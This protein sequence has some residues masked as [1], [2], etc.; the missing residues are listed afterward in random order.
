MLKQNSLSQYFDQI[1]L[2]YIMLLPSLLIY[3]TMSEKTIQNVVIA[4]LFIF[5]VWNKQ[6]VWTRQIT[7]IWLLWVLYA[8]W[9]CFAGWLVS[10]EVHGLSFVRA[11]LMLVF[12]VFIAW[13]QSVDFRLWL[14]RGFKLALSIGLFVSSY[15]VFIAHISRAKGDENSLIFAACISV[16][17]L[18]VLH[19]SLLKKRFSG[20]WLVMT[21]I[22]IVL[23]GSQ[24][25]LFSFI[26]SVLVLAFF[27]PKKSAFFSIVVP[28]FVLVIIVVAVSGLLHKKN[29]N[30]FEKNIKSFDVYQSYLDDFLHNDF[31]TGEVTSLAADDNSDVQYHLKGKYKN[32]LGYRLV[33]LRGGWEVFK[34]HPLTGVGAKYDTLKVGQALGV[35]SDLAKFSHVHNAFL[36]DM[37]TGGIVKLLLLLLILVV[38]VVFFHVVKPRDMYSLV[39]VMTI[40]F[41]LFGL[42]NVLF[43]ELKIVI[44][45]ALVLV[46]LFSVSR[47]KPAPLNQ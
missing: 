9:T 10:G 19:Q 35:G 40:N 8:A 45:Y 32:S 13:A 21:A 12:P 4:F 38:P 42:T 28:A 1:F 2:F 17:G 39:L 37:V 27:V 36:Q 47:K 22:I 15:Q 6:I 20:H 16:F 41:M 30:V 3:T 44:V 7:V 23:S 25:V 5:F 43:K 26:M 34:Q 46:P 29:N 18:F 14:L 33:L 11:A 24:G 31:S